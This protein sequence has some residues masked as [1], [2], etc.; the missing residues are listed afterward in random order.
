MSA[1]TEMA[2]KYG[3]EYTMWHNAKSKSINCKKLPRSEFLLCFA[4][5]R[6]CRAIITGKTAENKKN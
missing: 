2:T 4:K 5:G 1:W 3:E 6:P